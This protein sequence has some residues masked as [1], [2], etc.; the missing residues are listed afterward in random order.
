MSKNR[1]VIIASVG[2]ILALIV[3][4]LMIRDPASKVTQEPP[5]IETPAP[6]SKAFPATERP[7]DMDD[8]HQQ[9]AGIIDDASNAVTEQA[10][11]IWNRM[12]DYWNWIME[13]DAKH[14]IIL[15]AVIL[16]VVGVIVNGNNASK[17]KKN[18][19]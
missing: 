10:P 5:K 3:A 16:V 9:I 17:S 14:A 7:K 6:A 13:F 1:K 11:G 8:S 4:V 2:I 15:I 18:Q 19:H 12:V